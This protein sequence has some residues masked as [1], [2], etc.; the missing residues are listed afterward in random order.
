LFLL[1]VYFEC[2]CQAPYKVQTQADNNNNNNL[3]LHSSKYVLCTYY[4]IL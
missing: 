2:E 1:V 3:S 4:L